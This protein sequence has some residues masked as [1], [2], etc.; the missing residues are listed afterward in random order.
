M[1]FKM[2]PIPF[3][4]TTLAST[5]MI[6]E[7]NDTTK[8]DRQFAKAVVRWLDEDGTNEKARQSKKAYTNKKI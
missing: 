3:V 6:G 8:S 7:H 5:Y 2:K 1:E 4:S